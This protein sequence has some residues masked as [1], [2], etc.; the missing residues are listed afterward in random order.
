MCKEWAV[1]SAVSPQGKWDPYWT[2]RSVAGDPIDRTEA[3]LIARNASAG[4]PA[5]VRSC[6]PVGLVVLIVEYA[7]RGFKLLGKGE[8]NMKINQVS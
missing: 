3:Q 6:L 7:L 1:C 5:A 4:T 2:Q 8:P